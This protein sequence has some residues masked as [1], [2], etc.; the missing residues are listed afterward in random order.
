MWK[1]WVFTRM[2]NASQP[3]GLRVAR[4]GCH[5]SPSHSFVF[6][7]HVWA[8]F[9]T[10]HYLGCWIEGNHI[11]V[12]CCVSILECSMSQCVCFEGNAYR[13]GV[14]VCYSRVASPFGDA[15]R[16]VMPERHVPAEQTSPAEPRGVSNYHVLP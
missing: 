10:W 11:N 6:F 15:G 3:L 1:E 12:E 13:S 5:Y 8:R 14:Y 2:G 4:F 7:V 16:G 9:D